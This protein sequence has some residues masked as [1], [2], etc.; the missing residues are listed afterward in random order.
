MDFL[1]SDHVDAN[2]VMQPL[3]NV[4]S[5]VTTAWIG[6]KLPPKTIVIG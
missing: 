1:A 5:D 4:D 2:N 6:E 3:H